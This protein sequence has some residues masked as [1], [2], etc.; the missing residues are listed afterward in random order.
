[1]E[2]VRQ[3]IDLIFVAPALVWSMAILM[4]IIAGYMLHTYV[5][6]LLF[7]ICGSLVMFAAILVANVAFN[8]LG[9]AFTTDKESNI[10]ASAGAAI[11]SVALITILVLR[12]WQAAYLY[13]SRLSETPGASN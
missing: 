10:A 11:C 7:A 5:N 13:R 6:D 3:F 4:S 8:E 12:I 9:V 2:Q 1:M